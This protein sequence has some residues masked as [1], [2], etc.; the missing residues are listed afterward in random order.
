MQLT[1]FASI[2]G[3]TTR[4]TSTIF[5]VSTGPAIHYRRPIKI[6]IRKIATKKVGTTQLPEHS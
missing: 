3:L 5:D 6:H 2:Q 4:F 1:E